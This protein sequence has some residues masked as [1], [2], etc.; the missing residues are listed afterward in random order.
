MGKSNN[1]HLQRE[2][3]M[4]KIAQL[5][6]DI[7]NLG[8]LVTRTFEQDKIFNSIK[9][10]ESDF[11]KLTTKKTNSFQEKKLTLKSSQYGLSLD[12]YEVSYH[13]KLLKESIK[14]LNEYDILWFNHACPHINL[15]DK[16][17]SSLWMEFYRQTKG[18]KA[19]VITD[20]YFDK[21]Y[22]W[23]L[24]A[25]E[26]VHAVIG[27]GYGHAT[28]WEKY[29]K[30]DGI[31]QQPFFVDDLSFKKSSKRHGL[32]WT[33]Q[34][35]AWKGIVE[36][37]KVCSK[38]EEPTS[39]YGAGMEYYMIRKENPKLFE[40]CIGHDAF[41]K[42]VWNKKALNEIKGT[43]PPKVI[44]QMYQEAKA[45]I[46]FTCIDGTKKYRGHNNRATIE[47]MLYGCVVLCSQFLIEPYTHIPKD[48]V[49]VVNGNTDKMSNEINSLL[50]DNKKREKIASRS[51]DWV[52]ENH[53]GK[54]VLKKWIDFILNKETTHTTNYEYKN[55]TVA[56]KGKW[57]K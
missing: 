42:K 18:K 8:G 13:P 33:H 29:V 37:L 57:W 53:E 3:G 49:L 44:K 20:V 54:K 5:L 32:V 36:Y 43:V 14:K 50:K 26:N 7:N 6:P 11:F 4:I 46:D 15:E 21:Y 35:R 16:E 2:K 30:V 39:F 24:N 19:V 40:Q 45:A 48:C 34:W 27:G 1:R 38:L 25:I 23:F 55:K 17:D 41:A 10:V 51:F 28:S 47:P 31:M 56:T 22:P 9:G 52:E 12:Q